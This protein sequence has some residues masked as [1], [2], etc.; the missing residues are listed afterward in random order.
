MKVR[1]EHWMAMKAIHK[2]NPEWTMKQIGEAVGF[3][4]DV[5]SRA[6]RTASYA[7]YQTLNKT[8]CH[9]KPKE[10]KSVDPVQLEIEEQLEDDIADT[11]CADE[12][13]E[14]KAF[15]AI[16][17]ELGLIRNILNDILEV[18]EG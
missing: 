17:M 3:G 11:V 16:Q 13:N 10:E 12:W 2:A 1:E 5:A 4:P 8:L 6:I 15:E 9:K 18:L 7:E 14:P